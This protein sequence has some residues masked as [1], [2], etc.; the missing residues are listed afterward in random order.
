[1]GKQK[2]NRPFVERHPR[3]NSFFGLIVLLALLAIG[4]LIAYLCF[5]YIGIGIGK[6]PQS[7]MLLLL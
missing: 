2:D 6:L 3:W 4:I 1:M 5:K 7:L